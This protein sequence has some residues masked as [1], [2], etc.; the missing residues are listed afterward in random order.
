MGLTHCSAAA[1]LPQRSLPLQS[2][3]S[4]THEIDGTAAPSAATKVRN[5]ALNFEIFF[6]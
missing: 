2:L 6:S 4:T 3:N 5:P 1:Q